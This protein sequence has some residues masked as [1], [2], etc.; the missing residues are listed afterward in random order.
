MRIC[1]FENIRIITEVLFLEFEQFFIGRELKTSI[2]KIV[3]KLGSEKSTRTG[4]EVIDANVGD[5]WE[6]GYPLGFEI[7]V[8][9]EKS[10][11]RGLGDATVPIE[12]AQSD[13]IPSE[14][15]IELNA[16]HTA[17]PTEAQKDVFHTLTGTLP[18]KEVRK[19]LV[20]NMFMVSAYS[21]IDIQVVSPSG[22]R[23]GK[24]FETNGEYNDIPDAFYTGFDTDSEFIL[25]P[26]PEDGEYRI[27]TQGTGEGDYRIEAVKIT[28]GATPGDAA[29]ESLVTFAGTATPDAMEEKKIELLA[30]D[31][32]ISKEEQDA[33]PPTISI[34]S[35][36]N[37]SYLNN[38]SL[39]IAYTVTDNVSAET[40]IQKFLDRMLRSTT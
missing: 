5:F 28:E 7:P 34:A 19:S 26:N 38:Q 2:Y 17:L 24:N 13:N 37:K 36:E 30:D 15:L 4:F 32:V 31:T 10:I 6:H 9:R 16:A 11:R 20:G 25:I 29:K 40:D 1:F 12:S 35:P 14:Y 23:M 22:E 33:V 27:L 3:G 21:P 18:L 39:P 8:L